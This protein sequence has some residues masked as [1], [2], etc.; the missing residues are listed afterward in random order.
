PDLG[1]PY[2][3]RADAVGIGNCVWCAPI[4]MHTLFKGGRCAAVHRRLAGRLTSERASRTVPRHSGPYPGNCWSFRGCN[5]DDPGGGAVSRNVFP[6][7][8]H[9]RGLR[10]A[11]VRDGVPV[12]QVQGEPAD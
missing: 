1:T 3:T 7:P 9:P 11:P 2:E 8:A 4:R 5:A 10:V 12:L 6:G